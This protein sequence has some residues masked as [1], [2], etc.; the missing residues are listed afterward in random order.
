MTFADTLSQA[1]AESPILKALDGDSDSAGDAIDDDAGRSLDED[2]AG[3]DG[4]VTSAAD[5]DDADLDPDAQ[6]NED[7]DDGSEDDD[8]DAEEGADEALH[9]VTS[10]GETY[11]VSLQ[12]LKNGW[13]AQ[14]TFTKRSQ[15]LARERKEFEAERAEVENARAELTEIIEAAQE[16]PLS[17]ILDISDEGPDELIAQY[18]ASTEDPT[19]FALTLLASLDRSNTLHP[20]L[21]ELFANA[22]INLRAIAV[23]AQTEQKAKARERRKQREEEDGELTAAQRREQQANEAAMAKFERTWSAI[24][25][26]HDLDFDSEDSEFAAASELIEFCASRDIY[27]LS[28]GWEQLQARKQ[29]AAEKAQA[30]KQGKRQ[31]AAAQQPASGRSRASSPPEKA[32]SNSIF[33]EKKNDDPFSLRIAEL[34]DRKTV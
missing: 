14:K 33:N 18:A 17:L 15:A 22:G 9:T 11:E 19:A 23:K 12:E 7:D 13:I 8:E 6:D 2:V 31:R 25:E 27:D 4:D 24:K 3:N 32:T 28:A 5:D 20:E 26:D 34:V 10:E 30:V 21:S 1:L 29:R 16:D